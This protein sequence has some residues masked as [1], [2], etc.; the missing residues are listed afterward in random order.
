LDDRVRDEHLLMDGEIVGI[1]ENFSNG[2]PAPGEINCR[3]V[4]APV[5]I[6]V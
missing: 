6:I 5:R 1:R 2:L 4:I 3:C